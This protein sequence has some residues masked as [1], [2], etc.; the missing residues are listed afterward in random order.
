MPRL[1]PI[2]IASTVA[3]VESFDE[4]VLSRKGTASGND[5]TVRALIYFLA[6]HETH[7]VNVLKERYL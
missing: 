6:G 5:F 2:C 3:L 7:H 1:P 4:E